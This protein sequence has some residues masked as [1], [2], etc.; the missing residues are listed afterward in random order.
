MSIKDKLLGF[1][2]LASRLTFYLTSV[3]SIAVHVV[4]R[5]AYRNLTLGKYLK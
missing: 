4:P 2:S 3:S 1:V 5:E